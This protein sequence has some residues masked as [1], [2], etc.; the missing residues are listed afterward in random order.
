MGIGTNRTGGSTLRTDNRGQRDVLIEGERRGVE[1]HRTLAGQD[2]AG[3]RKGAIEAR[4][5]KERREGRGK[6]GETKTKDTNEIIY[7]GS[8]GV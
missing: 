1:T 2:P 8:G 3:R 4:Q 6:A 5:E 7:E